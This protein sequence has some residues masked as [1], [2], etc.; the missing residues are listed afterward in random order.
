MTLDEDQSECLAAAVR[1]C[2]PTE[3]ITV[4]VKFRNRHP[5]TSA[6]DLAELQDEINAACAGTTAW[7]YIVTLSNA[8]EHQT[9]AIIVSRREA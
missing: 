3:S 5:V 8:H 2:T 7:G 4:E 9:F 1:D 6:W